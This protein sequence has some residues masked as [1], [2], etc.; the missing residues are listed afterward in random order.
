M[1]ANDGDLNLACL[2]T[3]T[4]L[5]I[6]SLCGPELWPVISQVCRRF[7]VILGPNSFLWEQISKTLLIVNQTSHIFQTKYAQF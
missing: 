1:S 7:Y 5:I 3:D 4:L 2:P 6:F